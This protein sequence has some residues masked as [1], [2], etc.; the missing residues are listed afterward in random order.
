MKTINKE[1]IVKQFG[2]ADCKYYDNLYK[3]KSIHPCTKK[4]FI[5]IDIYLDCMSKKNKDGVKK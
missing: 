3:I 5:D 1:Y 2:C 4:G